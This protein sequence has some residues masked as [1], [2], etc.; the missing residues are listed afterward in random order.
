MEEFF[1]IALVILVVVG[2]PL[3][4]LIL[5]IVS[6][7]R[8]GRVKRL[9]DRIE[10]LERAV[11]ELARR[12]A[13]EEP[14]PRPV[15]EVAIEKEPVDEAMVEAVL[16]DERAGATGAGVASALAEPASPTP[17]TR[18]EPVQWELL[19][20]RKALG[21][22]AVVSL[23]FAAAFFL[24]YAIE[25]EWIGPLGRV[26]V[27]AVAGMALV[28]AGWNRHRRGWRVF[29]QMLTAAGVIVLYL[30]T[31]SAFGFYHL[32]PRHL[33][34]IF[35]AI[36]VLESA[37]VAVRYDSLA[38]ALTAV[39]GGLAT[40][41]LMRSEHDLYA[42]LFTYLAVLNLGV[43]LLL[44]P[45][46]WPAIG[47]V[48]VLGT[49]AL[50]WS[51]YAGNYHPEKLDWALGFQAVLFVLFLAD[52][53]GTYTL[54][55]RRAG[56]EDSGR[57]IL[58]AAFWFLAVYVLLKEDYGQWMGS[59]AVGMA[60]LYAALARLMLACRPSEPGPLF[61]SL[62]VAVG[63]VALAFPIQADANWVA[64]GWMAEAAVLWWFGLRVR[65][66]AL[67][68]L[69]GVLASFAVIRLVGFDIPDYGRE[70]FVPVFNQFALPAIGVAACL[71]AAVAAAR[72]FLK[73]LGDAE[74]VL[75]AMAGLAG[76]LL[77]W[78]VL[79]VDCYGFFD[80]QGRVYAADRAQWRWLGQMSVSVLWAVY[81][82]AALAAGFR[83]RLARLRWTALGLYVITVI[84][85]FLV[86]M[87][88]SGQI[89]RIVAFFVLAVFLGLAA[90]AYQRIR[91]ELVS[92]PEV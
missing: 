92:A 75:V 86:D 19:V 5:A 56:W 1:I 72:W 70:P 61:T 44:L 39:L 3:T 27:G 2:L 68:G 35:L 18:P 26:S 89:Y 12:P 84:K 54:R 85:V 67:R 80:A 25:N 46:A 49:Q 73:R 14:R 88:G 42:A 11:G 23:I 28:V 30:A 50:F 48:A 63:F 22:V 7:V 52:S 21:W 36:V 90:W 57:V 55:W 43:L 17:K 66:G 62:A 10:L 91:L 60:V 82:T 38:I 37:M 47:T 9:A 83:L 15:E 71:L 87:A 33:A 59:A 78:L 41:L 77:L 58:V 8:S 69:A 20:G 24:K 31:Y 13:L 4:A 65:A 53:L 64:F 34:A 76:I 81:A 40:P 45:R 32:L 16:V 29:S 51:W 6:L 74:R 79:T